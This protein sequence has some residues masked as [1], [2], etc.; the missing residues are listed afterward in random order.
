M[1]RLGVIAAMSALVTLAACGLEKPETDQIAQ[2]D[3]IGLS[4]SSILACMGRPAGR[5]AVGSTEIWSYPIGVGETEGQG[6]ATFGFPR[7]AACNVEVVLTAGRVS[8]V[9]YKG[10]AGDPLDLGEQCRFHVQ[11]CVPPR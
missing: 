11:S 2:A 1:G 3:M 8:Q 4:K 10:L 6:F 7:H 5:R 9:A